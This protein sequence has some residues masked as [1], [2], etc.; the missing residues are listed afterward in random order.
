MKYTVYDINYQFYWGFK[1]RVVFDR[2][3]YYKQKSPQFAG[4]W[5]LNYKDFRTGSYI[6]KK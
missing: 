6:L 2:K 4:F 1:L 5:L 3:K